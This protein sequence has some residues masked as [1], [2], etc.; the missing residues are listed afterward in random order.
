MH[1]FTECIKRSKS[2]DTPFIFHI[3]LLS[4]TIKFFMSHLHHHRHHHHHLI[5]SALQVSSYT[6]LLRLSDSTPSAVCQ[7]KERGGGGLWV[8]R[9]WLCIARGR[10]EGKVGVANCQGGQ[11]RNIPGER[12]RDCVL[13]C[14]E[15][16][17]CGG[18]SLC[19]T[20]KHSSMFPLFSS[21]FL[22]STI[23]WRNFISIQL[24]IWWF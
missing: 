7:Y 3:D 11:Q 24:T 21:L 14:V 8:T 9:V 6:T 4:A 12:W 1:P 22:I 20:T 18:F 13:K 5:S 17:T 16:G 23:P 15:E 10:R 2:I 19:Y